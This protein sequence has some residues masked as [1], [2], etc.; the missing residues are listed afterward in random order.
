MVKIYLK[1]GRYKQALNAYGKC[2]EINP[3]SEYSKKLKV[4]LS[5]IKTENKFLQ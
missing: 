3:T 4:K 5:K 2:L 1:T